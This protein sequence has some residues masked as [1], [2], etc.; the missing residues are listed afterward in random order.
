M[1]VRSFVLTMMLTA[2]AGWLPQSFVE[3]LSVA[4]VPAVAE[5]PIAGAREPQTS[6]SPQPPSAAPRPRPDAVPG[7]QP[8]PAAA[9]P[10]PA[11]PRRE[12]QPI[13]VRVEVTITDRKPGASPS[14]KTVTVV[15]GDGQRSSIRSEGFAQNRPTPLNVD[16][17]SAILSD[18]KIRVQLNLQYDYDVSSD[19]PASAGPPAFPG[20]RLQIRHALTTILESGKPIAVAQSADPLSD[21]QVTVEVKATILR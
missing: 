17:D 19:G 6:P 2:A 8:P 21:R 12:N 3:P 20:Q 11:A 18:N 1:T 13:N 9:P 15:A 7:S 16:V 4:G 14:A 5:Q 10:A